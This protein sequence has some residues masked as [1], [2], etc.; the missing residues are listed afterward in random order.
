M[1]KTKNNF[2]RNGIKGFILAIIPI[3][4]IELE[5][6]IAQNYSINFLR[7]I[8]F[9]VIIY[10]ILGIAISLSYT[11]FS[12]YYPKISKYIYYAII[13]IYYVIATFIFII[14]IFFQ[15]KGPLFS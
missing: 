7:K 8:F 13:I 6:M 2:L 1:K 11:F 14:S 9:D 5:S 10:G 4:V 12:Q 3:L 15:I